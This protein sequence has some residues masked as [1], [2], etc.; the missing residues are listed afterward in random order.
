MD[1]PA[2]ATRVGMAAL[3]AVAVVLAVA[4]VAGARR[5][6]GAVA[7][8]DG[9][10]QRWSQVHGGY[11]PNQSV[12]VRG[13]LSGVYR[14]ARPLA[15]LGANPNVLTAWTVWLALAVL[16][17]A[18]AGGRWRMLA[19]LLLV[20]SG[21]GDSLD[22]AV[23]VLTDRTSRWGYVLDSLVD[24]VNE[25]IFV[26]A[27]VVVGA[28][29]ALGVACGAMV[30]L[31]EYL[32]ARGS[33]AGGGDIGTITVGERPNRVALCAVGIHFSGV[34]LQSAPAIATASLALLTILTLV[35][36][37]QLVLAVRRQLID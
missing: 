7:G 2:E 37:V 5:P 36:L 9:F 23:A 33:N 1:W 21:L 10:L 13:W 30:L 20:V 3:G 16:L 35:G 24:R 34:F 8:L 32:R 12:W 25:I 29:P 11:N 6:S 18:A 31:L 28:P 15:R 26:A 4:T 14:F 22:G 19:G 17:A 27:V